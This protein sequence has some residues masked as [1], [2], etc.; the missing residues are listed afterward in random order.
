MANST[1]LMGSEVHE[2]QGAWMGQ[3]DLKATYHAAKVSPKDIQ[4]FRVVLPIELPKIMGLRGI[5]S[6][7]VLPW[8]GGL[9]FSPWWGKGGHNEG[10]VVNHLQTSHYHLG[11]FAATVWNTL[12]Q[13]LMP[14]AGTPC[15][16]SQ[17]WLASMTM[18]MTGR[19]NLMMMIMAENM[20]SSHSMRINAAP[21]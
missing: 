9:S 14:C 15:C 8:W 2:V 17:Y 5:H 18:T 10:M 21:S 12:P 6:P 19:R 4:F 7:K 3:K 1:N 16:V 11:L 13:A 20:M